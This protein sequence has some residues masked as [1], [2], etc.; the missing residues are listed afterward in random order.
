MSLG[1]GRKFGCLTITK[2]LQK[3][4]LYLCDCK[5]GNELE[6]FYSLLANKVQLDC[7]MCRPKFNWKGAVVVRKN[8]NFHS[9]MVS[10]KTRHRRGKYKG[11]LK[12]KTRTSA[13]YNSWASMIGR[14][15][16]LNNDAWEHYGGRGIRVCQ[17]WK[18]GK[19]GFFNFIR[20]MGPRPKGKSLDRINVQGHYEPTNCCWSTDAYQRA[21]QRRI[22]FRNKRIPKVERVKQMEERVRLMAAGH[23]DGIS[24][25]G[26]APETF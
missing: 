22:L 25:D 5:C 14:C 18:G 17:R 4:A 12:Y 6:I 8:I 23:F 21:N 9:R 26:Q 10:T 24:F 1:I 19:E 13:E 7:G 16:Q 3:D 2:E 11:I 15:E 20:D